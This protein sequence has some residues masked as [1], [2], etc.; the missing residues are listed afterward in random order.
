VLVVG[1]TRK[2]NFVAEAMPLADDD[3]V[4]VR[5]GQAAVQVEGNFFSKE[6]SLAKA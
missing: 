4:I 3:F 6:I 5:I 1:P 2:R